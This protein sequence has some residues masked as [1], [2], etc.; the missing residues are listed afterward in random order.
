MS[1]NQKKKRKITGEFGYHR[2]LVF[3]GV[4]DLL[5]CNRSELCVEYERGTGSGSGKV[6]VCV[7]DTGLASC[8]RGNV[9]TARSHR[10]VYLIINLII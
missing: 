1:Y 10:Y 2:L 6:R 4:H 3:N 8:L 5:R 7:E 9:V